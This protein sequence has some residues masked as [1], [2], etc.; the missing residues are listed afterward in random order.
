MFPSEEITREMDRREE[1]V[2]HLE[3]LNMLNIFVQQKAGVIV[4]DKQ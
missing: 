4:S 1:T 3:V 2:I